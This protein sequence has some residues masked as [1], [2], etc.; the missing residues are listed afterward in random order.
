MKNEAG[1]KYF[2]GGKSD[3]GVPAKLVNIPVKGTNSAYGDDAATLIKVNF[4][5]DLY[6]TLDVTFGATAVGL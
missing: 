3:G 2:F 1:N 4:G 6:T 5:T